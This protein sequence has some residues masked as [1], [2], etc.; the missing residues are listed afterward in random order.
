MRTRPMRGGY[1]M[2]A[3]LI[4]IVLFT[5]LWGVA[6]RQT[7]A[8]LRIESVQVARVQRDQGSTVA[9]ARGLALLQTGLP[10]QSPYV[11]GVTLNTPAGVQSFTVTFAA[12]GGS[13]WSVQA[14]PTP[15][16]Q[17]PQPMP[18]TFAP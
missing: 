18:A 4:F 12:Q 2:V 1:A 7:A 8:A 11:C 5:A 15:A 16:G 17:S 14:G 3:T 6:Y 10:P 9:L 13:N